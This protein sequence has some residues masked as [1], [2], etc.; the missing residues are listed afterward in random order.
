MTFGEYIKDLRTKKNLSQRDMAEMSGVSNAE[1]SRLETG[2]RKKPSPLV[3]KA[4]APCLGV[5]NE[6]LMEKA[7]YIE[8]IIPRGGFED[9]LWED[10]DGTPVDTFRRQAKNISRRDNELISI[11][12]RAVNKSSDQDIDTIKKLLSSFMDD[13]LTD[14]QKTALRAV[15]EGFTKK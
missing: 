10:K 13:G 6:D 1:I 7:G 12:D 15:I 2:D 14:T 9:I 3:I 11:L 4:I 5:S 8:K